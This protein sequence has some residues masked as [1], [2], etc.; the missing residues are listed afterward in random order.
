MKEKVSIVIPAYNS[1][2]YIKDC[3]LSLQN[4]TYKNIEI[5]V[6]NDGSKDS[7]LEILNS[8]AAEYKN[9]IVLSQDNHGIAYTR[10]RGIEFASGE[11]L[12]FMDNDDSMKED[13]VETL[14][15]TIIETNADMVVG[16]YR[17]ITPDGKV[18]EQ[19]VLTNDEWAKFKMVSPWG[20]IMK[21]SFVKE[22]NL[23]FGDFKMGEDSYFNVT[24]YG[25]S[26]KIVTTD[27]VGYN[28]IYREE[29]V[30]NTTQKKAV[31]SPIHFLEALMER[32]KTQKYMNPKMFEFFV[33]KYVIWNLTFICKQS[34]KK[35][36]SQAYS[37]YFKWLENAIPDFRKNPYIGLGKPKGETALIRLIVTLFCKM[38][39]SV[40][41]CIMLM[42][43]KISK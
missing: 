14:L 36:I 43:K 37:D 13:C 33:I 20:R 7:T 15:K 22:H 29:S 39:K 12:M 41:I 30:S 9:L 16:G 34:T 5:I 42:Y 6:V 8:L 3:I 31:N 19:M 10:N 23:K 18:L 38:P 4:Q 24:A 25:E 32:N 2:K 11:Y 27:Y 21:T 26:D 35:E 40:V 28:W 1:E 17:R